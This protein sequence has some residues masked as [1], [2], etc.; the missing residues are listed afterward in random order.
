MAN[1]ASGTSNASSDSIKTLSNI[2]TQPSS[3]GTD[4]R[5]DKVL[6]EVQEKLKKQL[7]DRKNDLVD[8]IYEQKRQL[9]RATK[10][11]EEAGIQ[12]YD[13][14]CNL[15]SLHASLNKATVTLSIATQSHTKV[16]QLYYKL[17]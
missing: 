6:E 2:S 13:L 4:H 15:S 3:L 17:F 9:L 7:L 5:D 16:K 10:D 14:Q 11:R 8:Q 12:L 1:Q